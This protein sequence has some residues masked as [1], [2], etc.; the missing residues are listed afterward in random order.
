MVSHDIFG[1]PGRGKH[2]REPEKHTQRVIFI[3]DFIIHG[4]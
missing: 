2:L 4:A 1:A 3:D